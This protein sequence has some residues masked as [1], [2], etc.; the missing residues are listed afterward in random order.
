[1]RSGVKFL[2]LTI[3]LLFSPFSV[4]EYEG[5]ETAYDNNDYYNN[6]YYGTAQVLPNKG[7]VKILVVPV[8]FNDSNVFFNTSQKEQILEDIEYTMNANRPNTE[9][10]S[11]K[12]YYE[13]QSHGAITMDITVSDFYSSTTSYQNYTDNIESKLKHKDGSRIELA[14]DISIDGIMAMAENYIYEI[15]DEGLGPVRVRTAYYSA[16]DISGIVEEACRLAIEHLQIN[17]LSTPIPLNKSM[18]EKAFDKIRPSIY[19]NINFIFN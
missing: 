18:F 12:Q 3:S 14:S 13:A 15:K 7:N 2:S 16:A 1:M 11:V 17:K 19:R 6:S 9:L 8:W 5:K 4:E 10:S